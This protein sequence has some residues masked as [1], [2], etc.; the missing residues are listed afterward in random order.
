MSENGFRSYVAEAAGKFDYPAFT[1]RQ[2]NWVVSEKR[3][4]DQT[5]KRNRIALRPFKLFAGFFISA[6]V[7]SKGFSRCEWPA[8]ISSDPFAISSAGTS[9]RA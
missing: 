2:Y 3:R 9:R 6:N 5:G 4:G 1:V 7:R 8:E